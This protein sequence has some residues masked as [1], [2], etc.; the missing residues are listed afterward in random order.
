MLQQAFQQDFVPTMPPLFFNANVSA[1]SRVGSSQRAGQKAGDEGLQ[2]RQVC[3][4]VLRGCPA[5]EA[6]DVK[7]AHKLS[8][9]LATAEFPPAWLEDFGRQPYSELTL[10]CNAPAFCLGVRW[11]FVGVFYNEIERTWQCY[12]ENICRL[13]VPFI[14]STVGCLVHPAHS[15]FTTGLA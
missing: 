4:G 7:A 10:S 9:S 13:T 14:A 8:R 15:P 1:A 12:R 5:G 11:L 6:Y 2:D 3:R